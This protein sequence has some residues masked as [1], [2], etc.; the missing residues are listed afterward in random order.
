MTGYAVRKWVFY[1]R[2]PGHSQ[3]QG[4]KRAITMQ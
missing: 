2:L 3:H 1:M 4:K